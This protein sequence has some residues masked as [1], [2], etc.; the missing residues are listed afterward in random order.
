MNAGKNKLGIALGSIAAVLVLL[1]AFVVVW[2][3]PRGPETGGAA[4]TTGSTGGTGATVN[5]GYATGGGLD[6]GK[7]MAPQGSIAGQAA[8]AAT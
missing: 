8:G 3:V 4:G 7:A 5:S 2:L 6:S 1:A